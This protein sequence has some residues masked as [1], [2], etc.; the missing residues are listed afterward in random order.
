MRQPP[1]DQ[2]LV[3][4]KAK[5]TEEQRDKIPRNRGIRRHLVADAIGQVHE[6]SR[7]RYGYRRVQAALRIEL[8]LGVNHTLVA[9]GMADLGLTGLPQKKIRKRNLIGVRT[10]GDLVNREFTAEQPNRTKVLRRLLESK[11]PRCFYVLSSPV[12]AGKAAAELARDVSLHAPSDL[13]GCAS[14]R[15]SSF[16]VSVSRRVVGHPRQ[17][18]R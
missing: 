17:S 18:E 10:S 13:L 16:D 8:N 14:F 2:A 12:L 1:P 15:A 4:V 11:N 3:T 7:G 6:H 5:K 9:K